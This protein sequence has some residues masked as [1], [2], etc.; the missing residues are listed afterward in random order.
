VQG[1]REWEWLKDAVDETREA[2]HRIDL[3]LA[4]QN[5]VLAEH[6]KRT[7]ALEKRVEGLWMRAL[8][9]LGGM[10]GLAAG[11][12]KLYELVK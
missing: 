7:N 3:T 4:S 2:I 11:L 8:S 10:V 12:L 5:V 1:S 6:V 9:T